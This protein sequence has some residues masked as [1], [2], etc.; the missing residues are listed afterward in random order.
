MNHLES[1][2]ILISI[3]FGFRQRHSCEFQLLLITDNFARYL[4]N[5]TQVDIGILN[6]VKAF[7]KVPHKRLA[8]KLDHYGIRGKSLTWIQS[9]LQNRTQLVVIDGHHSSLTDVS[10]GVLQGTVLS[11]TLF[12]IY[13]IKVN[14][15]IQSQVHLLL[16]IA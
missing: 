12:L 11:P 14:T 2:N 3:Q 7:D 1:H 8:I 10:S 15:N 4:D 13:I 16:I 6:F 9:F 5:T